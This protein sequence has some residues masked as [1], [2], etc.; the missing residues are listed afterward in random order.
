MLGLC[1]MFEFKLICEILLLLNMADMGRLLCVG[2]VSKAE[3]L[4][5]SM[6]MGR[7]SACRVLC[8]A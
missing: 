1:V 8:C 3:H 6:H 7:V 2:L 5:H 4:L